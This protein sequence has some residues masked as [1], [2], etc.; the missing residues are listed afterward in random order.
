MLDS[1]RRTVDS[2]AFGEVLI[3]RFGVRQP[4]CTE[5]CAV[6]FSPQ[7]LQNPHRGS[8]TSRFSRPVDDLH[9]VLHN[10][11]TPGRRAG[12]TCA[13]AKTARDK[14]GD[15]R[16]REKSHRRLSG[17][18]DRN[19]AGYTFSCQSGARALPAGARSLKLTNEK[20]GRAVRKSPVTDER[21][22]P[23]RRTYT[24]HCVPFLLPLGGTSAR[25]SH[26]LTAPR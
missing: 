23:H 4:V 21:A 16:T 18:W 3:R 24:G 12:E 2:A 13:D 9:F 1:A 14:P 6:F 17:R 15:E 26:S 20:R 11:A 19:S 10:S 7:S 22:P 25:P 5:L 8:L